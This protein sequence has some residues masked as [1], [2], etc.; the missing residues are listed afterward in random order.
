MYK[1][2]FTISF[3]RGNDPRQRKTYPR[4]EDRRQ[5]LQDFLDFDF[6]LSFSSD[7]SAKEST[8]QQE[9]QAWKD[10]YD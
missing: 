5:P 10:E 8:Y 1:Y 2:W 3:K 4:T 9:D 6:V 7:F